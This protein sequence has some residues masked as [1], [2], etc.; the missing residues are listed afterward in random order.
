MAAF[1]LNG[2]GEARTLKLFGDLIIKVRTIRHD[3]ERRV[4]RLCQ[5]A[6]LGRQKDHRQR[7]ARALC[8]V[9]YPAPALRIERSPNA[10][11]RFADGHKLLIAGELLD[12]PPFDRLEHHEVADEIEQVGGSEQPSQQ[13]VLPVGVRPSCAVSASSVRG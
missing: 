5:A 12:A 6:Q 9:D 7:L 11:N 1:G 4:F 8:V 13:D 3:D 10:F 2:I